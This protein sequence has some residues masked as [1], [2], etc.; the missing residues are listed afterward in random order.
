MKLPLCFA[1]KHCYS[2][3]IDHLNQH[4]LD[5]RFCINTIH[6]NPIHSFSGLVHQI[7]NNI[8]NFA[9]SIDWKSTDVPSITTFSGNLQL[10]YNN[11]QNILDLNWIQITI[12]KKYVTQGSCRLF[13]GL[14]T[15]T[16]NNIGQ[17]PYPANQQELILQ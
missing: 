15:C 4:N 1:E 12:N 17:L 11:S 16:K 7:S 5:G 6:L 3:Y 2:V 13:E 14:E 9:F 8:Y 10:S